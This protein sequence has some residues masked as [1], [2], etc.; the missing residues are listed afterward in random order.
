MDPPPDNTATTLAIA[1]GD[2]Q[3]GETNTQ[4]ASPLQAKVTNGSGDPVAGTSVSW[5]ATGASVSAPSVP[6]NSAGIS[7]VTVTLGSVAGPVT[8]VAESNGLTGSPLTFGATALVPE[9]PPASASVTVRN[10]N[11]LSVRNGTANAAVD[12]IAVGGTVTWTWAALATNPHDVTSSG[13]PSF[14][15]STTT[16]QPFTY[17]PVTFPTAGTYVY[18]CTQHGAP[19]VG[20]RGRIVVR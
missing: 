3:S 13:S 12:T 6:S 19:T 2:G 20:M 16:A 1:G 15:S 9:P 4:L 14:A 10:D 8:I 7:Q 17:G 5:S 11:F 18:Y